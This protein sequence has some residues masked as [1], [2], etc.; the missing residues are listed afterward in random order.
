[1]FDVFADLLSSGATTAKVLEGMYATARRSI[2]VTAEQRRNR[3][4]R[5]RKKLETNRCM[6]LPISAK[7][8]MYDATSEERA[9]QI[10]PLLEC[11]AAKHIVCHQVLVPESM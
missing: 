9:G 7:P 1:M 6:T 2:W 10:R 3:V 11:C 8:S 5:R 4:V